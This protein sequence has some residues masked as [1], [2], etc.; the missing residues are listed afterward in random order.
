MTWVLLRSSLA[1]TTKR[2][3]T[4]TKKKDN[5]LTP[6]PGAPH[7]HT[8]LFRTLLAWESP[9]SPVSPYRNLCA[10][11]T[12]P[13]PLVCTKSR[14]SQ[15]GKVAIVALVGGLA[16][17]LGAHIHRLLF[18]FVF[19]SHTT[20]I[21][22]YLVEIVGVSPSFCLV[23]MSPFCLELCDKSTTYSFRVESRR[24]TFGFIFMELGVSQY[25]Y[26]TTKADKKSRIKQ[27]N[28]EDLQRSLKSNVPG[29][30]WRNMNDNAKG[31]SHT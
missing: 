7:T 23:L 9:S 4:E 29:S 31:P 10:R 30:M 8:L 26:Q 24:L 18:C 3:R 1:S 13:S 14:M 22:I 12:L 11:S 5:C 15:Q 28:E 25:A 20:T 19:Q 17:A 2:H 21:W 6:P 16:V 27:K